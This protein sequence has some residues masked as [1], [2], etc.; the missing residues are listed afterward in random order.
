MGGARG[1]A[2]RYATLH[3]PPKLPDAL[4]KGNASYCNSYSI[5]YEYKIIMAGRGEYRMILRTLPFCDN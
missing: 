1:T 5:E 3:G 2:V 4:L